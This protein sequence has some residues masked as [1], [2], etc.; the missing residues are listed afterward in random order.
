MLVAPT[1]NVE[2]WFATLANCCQ[3][4]KAWNE[5]YALEQTAQSCLVSDVP[6]FAVQFQPCYCI[7]QYIMHSPDVNNVNI[8]VAMRCTW[9]FVVLCVLPRAQPMRRPRRNTLYGGE[10]KRKM[11]RRLLYF[12]FHEFQFIPPSERTCG[13]LLPASCR[14]CCWCSLPFLLYHR[15]QDKTV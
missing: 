4:F 3:T 15:N 2:F 11:H 8:Y 13:P 7:R 6:K 14:C 10:P 12:V 9:N 1:V 5:F